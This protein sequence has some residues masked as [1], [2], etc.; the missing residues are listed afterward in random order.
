VVTNKIRLLAGLILFLSINMPVFAQDANQIIVAKIN[1]TPITLE[2][3]NKEVGE[4]NYNLENDTEGRDKYFRIL[5][6]ERAKIII[7]C[8]K[9][10]EQEESLVSKLFKEAKIEIYEDKIK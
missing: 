10:L 9:N 7:A 2:G 1:D 6:K 8:I 3:L 5:C 4:H